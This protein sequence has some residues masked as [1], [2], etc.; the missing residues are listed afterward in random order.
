[1]KRPA[2]AAARAA[3]ANQQPTPRLRSSL[4]L[5]QHA[6]CVHGRAQDEHGDGERLQPRAEV[7]SES[8]SEDTCPQRST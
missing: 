4:V 6:D 3:S 8:D 1:M 5:V 2:A 7:G